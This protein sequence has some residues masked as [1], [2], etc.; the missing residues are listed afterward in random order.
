MLAHT[1]GC[2]VPTHAADTPCQLGTEPWMV[3]LCWTPASSLGENGL[4]CCILQS[5]LLCS[6]GPGKPTQWLIFP[7]CTVVGLWSFQAEPHFL[8]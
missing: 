5:V 2:C 1:E 3:T 8:G 4:L 6:L 7:H